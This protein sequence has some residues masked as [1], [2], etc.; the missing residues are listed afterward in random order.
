MK[1]KHKEFFD[2]LVLLCKEYGVTAIDPGEPDVGI[3]FNFD[4][5]EYSVPISCYENGT[6]YGIIDADEEEEE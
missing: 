3:Y 2:E 6:I 5:Y 1:D 4:D